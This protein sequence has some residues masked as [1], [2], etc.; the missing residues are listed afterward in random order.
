M[1]SE[2]IEEIWK[3][4]ERLEVKTASRNELVNAA[5]CHAIT[6]KWWTGHN[7]ST[8]EKFWPFKP[9]FKPSITELESLADAAAYLCAAIEKILEEGGAQ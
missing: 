5:I 1:T 2:A 7:L 9:R 8:A 3:A 6:L 4:R